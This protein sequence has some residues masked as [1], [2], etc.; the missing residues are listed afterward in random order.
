MEAI[1]SS[2]V[3]FLRDK[4]VSTKIKILRIIIIFMML[5][6]V[7]NYLGFTYYHNLGQ[8]INLIEKIEKAKSSKEVNPNHKKILIELEE[9]IINRKNV[10]TQCYD[11]LSHQ[12]FSEKQIKQEAQKERSL[13]AHIL[14]SSIV[15]ILLFLF[16]LVA[17]LIDRDEN[18][19]DT[20]LG[21]VMFLVL[22]GGLTFFFQWALA[23]I[24]IIWGNSSYNYLLNIII[25]IGF[26]IPIIL[27]ANKYIDDDEE[28]IDSQKEQ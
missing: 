17:I 26:V 24:P 27:L 14:S 22:L 10:F 8:K 13:L 3:K 11:Y 23:F 20:I 5:F 28:E 2:V 12:L 21:I 1:I 18:D 4:S 15:W 7:N 19:S 6:G 9:E 16:A 25:Q